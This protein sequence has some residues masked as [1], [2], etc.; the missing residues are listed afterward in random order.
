[1]GSL[2]VA[3]PVGREADMAEVGLIESLDGDLIGGMAVLLIFKSSIPYSQPRLLRSQMESV[4]VLGL[5]C[6]ALVE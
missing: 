5:G 4:T 1:M 3:V 2:D 6:S